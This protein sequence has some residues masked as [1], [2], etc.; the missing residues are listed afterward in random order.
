MLVAVPAVNPG[1]SG[2]CTANGLQAWFGSDGKMRFKFGISSPCTTY[3]V[4]VCRY[5]LTDPTITP[6]AG[7]VPVACGVRN[8]MSAYS[9]TSAEWAQGFI[10]RVADPQPT[11]MSTAGMGS[12][13]YSVDITCNSGGSCTTTNRTRTYIFVPGI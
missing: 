5:N 1:S 9:P 8:S 13:W 4:Q 10:E 12:F 6:S 7:A 3:T 2:V 11:N